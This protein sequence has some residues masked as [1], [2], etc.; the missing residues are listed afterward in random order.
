ME[1]Q[2]TFMMTR[3]E[4]KELKKKLPPKWSDSLSKKT[5][6]SKIYIQQVMCGM[7]EHIRI[8]E[9]A[10]ELATEHQ[11]RLR[12]IDKLKQTLL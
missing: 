9:A 6:F 12:R 8:E 10:L 11:R 2:Y 4:K 5:G 7:T 3:E 1:S